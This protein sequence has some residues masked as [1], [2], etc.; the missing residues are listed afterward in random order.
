[1]C[2]HI[3][4]SAPTI[5]VEF[6]VLCSFKI[7]SWKPNLYFR[8]T[9]N[10][11]NKQ[12]RVGVRSRKEHMCYIYFLWLSDNLPSGL[13]FFSALYS[14]HDARF[15]LSMLCNCHLQREICVWFEPV[16]RFRIMQIM[17]L[18]L[19]VTMHGVRGSHVV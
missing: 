5:G 4:C 7:H 17:I 12:W 9:I 8:Y 14:H 19:V 1:M 15:N 6:L 3:L 2:Q 10:M 13:C 18:Y 11:Q 16:K